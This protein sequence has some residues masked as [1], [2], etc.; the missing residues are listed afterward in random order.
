MSRIG[1]MPVAL[2]A[3]VKV[4]K[5]GVN[6]TVEGPKGSISFG[7]HQAM[8]IT[9]DDA[10]RQ[11]R[12]ERPSDSKQHRALH[13]LTRALINNMVKGV[14]DPYHKRLEING[15]GYGG[16][17]KGRQLSLSVGFAHEVLVDIPDGVTVEAKRPQ[18]INVYGVDK[19]KVGDFAARAR[20]V[21]PPEP[22]N[23][24]GIRYGK[25]KDQAEEIIKRKSGKAFGSGDK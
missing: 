9:I 20:K 5:D 2:P 18:V 3:G 14:V 16:A 10:K 22:Y 12:V 4:T 6:V 17:V 25:S 13:G 19:Q 8:G 15:V 1:K 11:V 24:K 23:G 21:R 7:F